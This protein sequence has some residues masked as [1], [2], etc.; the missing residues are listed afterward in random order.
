MLAI[1]GMENLWSDFCAIAIVVD[2]AGV[3]GS[4]VGGGV[5]EEV[6]RDRFFL[7]SASGSVV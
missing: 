2:G 6:V 1:A 3:T 5:A 4:F 7:R